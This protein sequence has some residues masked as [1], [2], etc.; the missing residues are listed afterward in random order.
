[1]QLLLPRLLIRLLERFGCSVVCRGIRQLNCTWHRL[2]KTSQPAT[3]ERNCYPATHTWDIKEDAI[4]DKDD[5]GSGDGGGGNSGG[6]ESPCS[7][8]LFWLGLGSTILL[9]EIGWRWHEK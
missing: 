6:R 8:V 9:E 5:N 7:A 4:K 2:A 3:T 1:M